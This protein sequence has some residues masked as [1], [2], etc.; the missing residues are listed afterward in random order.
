MNETK[1]AENKDYADLLEIETAGENKSRVIISKKSIEALEDIEFYSNLWDEK[2]RI[3][4]SSG[5][6]Y[7]VS[8]P[9]EVMI[10]IV[11]PY[12]RIEAR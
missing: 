2:T 3:F 6:A 10:K 4:L 5:R 9:Y 12:R 1:F 7:E 11:W 8:I